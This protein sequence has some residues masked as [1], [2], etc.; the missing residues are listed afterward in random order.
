MKMAGTGESQSDS[1]PPSESEKTASLKGSRQCQPHQAKME[2]EKKK[3]LVSGSHYGKH[4]LTHCGQW[5]KTCGCSP[6]CAKRQAACMF[7][8]LVDF[9]DAM[10]IPSDTCWIIAVPFSTGKTDIRAL[11]ITM[12]DGDGRFEVRTRLSSQVTSIGSKAKKT[13]GGE[14]EVKMTNKAAVG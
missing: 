8:A 2:R 11:S 13:K 4:N 5:K 12:I 10:P 6:L 3:H 14:L 7:N 1:A 9:L